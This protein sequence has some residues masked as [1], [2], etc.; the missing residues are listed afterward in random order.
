MTIAFPE[1]HVKNSIKSCPGCGAQITGLIIDAFI[2]YSIEERSC[3]K[4]LL[5]LHSLNSAKKDSFEFLVFISVSSIMR[6]SYTSIL[7]PK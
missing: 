7:R 3:T 2:Y 1:K 5:K 4:E 6:T